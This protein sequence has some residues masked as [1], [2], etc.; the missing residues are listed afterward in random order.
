MITFVGLGL[1]DIEDISIKGYNAVKEADE[2][3]IEFYTSRISSSLDEIEKFFG[4][5]VRVLERSDL[6][7]NSFKIIEAGKERDV[8]ILTPGDPMVATTHSS[9]KLEAERRGVKTRI[10]HGASIISAVCG[11]TG[12]H[13]YRF[14]K[15]ATVSWHTSRTPADVIK[16]NLKIDAHTLLFLDLH[17]SPMRVNDAIEKL[18]VIDDGLRKVYGVGI[19]RAGSES[20]VVRCDRLERLKDIDFGEPLHILII[21]AKTLHFMEYECLREF[22]SAPEELKRLVV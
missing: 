18:I 9:I 8:V 22:A 2:V 12:L 7:E 4:R 13:N 20:A 6:E 3:F 15:S 16:S 21:L 19:A 1:W 17:P 11:L 5:N 14:G 10:I